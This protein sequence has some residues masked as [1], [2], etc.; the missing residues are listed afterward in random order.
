MEDLSWIEDSNRMLNIEHDCVVE[1]MTTIRVS[2][3]FIN[4]DSEIA[5]IVKETESLEND[6]IS[7]NRVGRMVQDKKHHLSKRYV[8]S[9]ILV[10]NI[11]SGPYIQTKV[12]PLSCGTIREIKLAPSL[13]VFHQLNQIFIFM[14]ETKP[15]HTRRVQFAC[16]TKSRKHIDK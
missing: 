8:L 16:A 7:I 9:D 3:I 15:K 5:Y 14:Q 10:Y 6:G 4:M 12:D 11:Q 13:F 2:Y 1:P